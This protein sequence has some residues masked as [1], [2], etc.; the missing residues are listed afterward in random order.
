MKV[1]DLLRIELA[2]RNFWYYCQLMAGNFYKQD[3]VYLREICEGM[4]S[5]YESDD[6]VLIINLPPRHGKSRT[7][8]MF[9]QWVYGRNIHEKVMTGSY[10]ETL[11]ISF[12]KSVRNAILET[13]GDEDIIVYSDVY[14]NIQIKKGDGATDLW[15]LEGGYN[16]YLATS[17]SGTA[18]GFGATI[19][20]IDD[21]IKNDKEA[22]NDVYLA[23]QWKW[24][25]DTMLSRLEEKGKIIIIMQRWATNDLAGRAIAHFG[26]EKKKCRIITMKAVQDDGSMLCDEIL[27][28]ES[29][30][31]KI[32]AMGYDIA[33][34]NY[35]QIPIDVKGRLYSSFKTYDTIPTNAEGKSL[36]TRIVAYVD[37]ADEGSDN[38]SGLICGVYNNEAYVLDVVH[39]KEPMEV[40]ESL[41]AS[42]LVEHD[43][44][45]VWIESNNGG[46]GFARSVERLLQER[47]GSNKT[48]VQWFHQS[49]NK[50]ARILSN[51]TWVM[52]HIYFPSNWKDRFNSYYV[53]MTTYQREGKNAHD[54]A[55]DATTGIAERLS[56]NN[57]WGWRE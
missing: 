3:R 11:S 31:M 19:M 18:M 25:T 38:L 20:I 15:T 36:F 41:V 57:S 21:L 40:T 50:R 29:Y 55:P 43:V 44:N 28:H 33:S 51:S 35:Q 37:T 47:Y 54:D 53:D 17:P 9:T 27:S 14:P 23:S 22:Y 5:F 4:Q 6:D 52:E 45:V 8:S 48:V 10:N 24:F 7:A 34:A 13:K 1:R 46:R 56:T 2:R 32:R 26:E 16:S 42:K 12:S 39:T 30:Q 49:K